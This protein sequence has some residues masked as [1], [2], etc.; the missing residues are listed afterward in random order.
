MC[1]WCSE[2][3]S[4]TRPRCNLVLDGG[5]WTG[6]SVF[7]ETKAQLEALVAGFPDAVTMVELSTEVSHA[8]ASGFML[9]PTYQVPDGQGGTAAS[10]GVDRADQRDAAPLD[11][12]FARPA[13]SGANVTIYMID[14]GIDC[15]HPVFGG[16][17]TAAY[18]AYSPACASG[19]C[20]S[21]IDYKCAAD[22]PSER[23]QCGY[24][25]SGNGHGTHVAGTAIGTDVGVATGA[26][27]RS[28]KVF[29]ASGRGETQGILQA[30]NFIAM[31]ASSAAGPIIINMSLEGG[32]D[33]A[34]EAAIANLEAIGVLCVVAAGNKQGQDACAF[35][36]SSST[37]AITV[38]SVDRGTDTRS[39]FSNT[40]RCVD[41][42][43]GG[44]NIV[45]ALPRGTDGN[46]GYQL[47]SGTSMAVP[48]VTG[49][50]AL[51]MGAFVEANAP[52]P[53]PAAIK[54]AILQGATPGKIPEVGLLFDN[55]A[56]NKAA[57]LMVY[58][59]YTEWGA[60]LPT[61]PMPPTSGPQSGVPFP[62]PPQTSPP[63][64][65]SGKPPL[66]VRPAL[67]SAV[68]CGQ[69][70]ANK[71]EWQGTGQVCYCDPACLKNDDCCGNYAA[72]CEG[73]PQ[74]PGAP[75][76]KPETCG[77]HQDTCGCDYKCTAMGD[78][79]VG[80]DT[81]AESDAPDPTCD[82]P[83][84]SSGKHSFGQQGKL[85]CW[86]M[87]D[88]A[89]YND[90]CG[91][92]A[93]Y[94]QVCAKAAKNAVQSATSILSFDAERGSRGG[95]VYAVDNDDS[96]DGGD[97]NGGDGGGWYGGDDDGGGGGGFGDFLSDILGGD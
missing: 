63:D 76:C 71:W 78:C 24:D 39:V 66:S 67:C 47:A 95:T 79:C 46:H 56:S 93:A 1:A 77:T 90:C 51:Y 10:W 85:E 80:Y 30:L 91:G 8:Q 72:V 96:N 43:A 59:R 54:A 82:A 69:P 88:C 70:L 26:R 19:G 45:S 50:A 18:D 29:D 48:V 41:I 40:G 34:L 73:E 52:V 42:F 89:L 25:D 11:A 32:K 84:C 74:A 65:G 44:S 7:V 49:I 9:Q 14:T 60:P 5:A 57:N 21:V 2:D 12:K 31:E 38:G 27:V 15:S 61:P 62:S 4:G 64:A 35:S 92:T 33:P 55:D 6:A 87:G 58:S 81:C 28:V 83:G 94:G 53:S 20:Q 22:T 86:C 23:G 13:H 36:P 17:C 75:T 37:L 97:D 16:R 3:T 68:N